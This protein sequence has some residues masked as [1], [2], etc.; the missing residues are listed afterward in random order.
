MHRTRIKICGITR[1]ED[2]AAAVDAGADA[3]GMILHAN[4]PRMISAAIANEIIDEVPDEVDV[5]GVFVDAPPDLIVQMAD[6]L[7][8]DQVQLHGNEPPQI[9]E[10]LAGLTIVKAIRG[11]SGFDNELARWRD[12][13]GI[14]AL[15]LETGR[16]AH[17]G[18]NGIESDWDALAALL[19]GPNPI[20][21]RALIVAGGLRADNV[22]NVIRRLQPWSVDV[23]SGV[24]TSIGIKSIAK[25]RAFCDAVRTT[26]HII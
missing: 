22:A 16:G 12:V 21:R 24:E 15:L 9:V 3:I 5:V 11:Q 25:M 6:D 8:L 18:G 4:A 26:D 19:S 17:A 20:D 1:P 13:L 23:S 7:E 2:A 10:S 14:R